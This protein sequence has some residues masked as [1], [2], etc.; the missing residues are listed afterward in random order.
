MDYQWGYLTYAIL[1]AK[2]KKDNYCIIFSL[3]G[4]LYG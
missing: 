1:N 3:K 2:H 4:F